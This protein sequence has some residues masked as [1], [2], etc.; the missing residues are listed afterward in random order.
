[1]PEWNLNT[2]EMTESVPVQK[3]NSPDGGGRIP[4]TSALSGSNGVKMPGPMSGGY[5]EGWDDGT[6]DATRGTHGYTGGDSMPLGATS[7]KGREEGSDSRAPGGPTDNNHFGVESDNGNLGLGDMAMNMSK[8]GSVGGNHESVHAADIVRVFDAVGRGGSGG[9]QGGAVF[10]PGQAMQG[11][12]L[13]A[14]S[15]TIPGYDAGSG[16]RDNDGY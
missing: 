2:G 13:G 3:A 11:I 9:G 4:D 7:D 1:M 12:P 14:G 15:G 10:L 8:V 5:E 6:S 16:D